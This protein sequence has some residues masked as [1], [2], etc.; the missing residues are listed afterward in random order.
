MRGSSCAVK[1]RNM[2][3]VRPFILAIFILLGTTYSIINPVLES[4]D[5]E[6]NY[7]NALYIVQN[8]ALPVL[9]PDEKSKAHHPP[10]YYLLTAALIDNIDHNKNNLAELSAHGNRFFG[11]NTYVPGVDNKIQNLPDPALTAFPWRGATLGIHI[12][13]LVSVIMGAGA[14]W[15]VAQIAWLL[16]K[17]DAISIAALLLTAFN[18]MFL[19][20]QSSVHN[21][22]LTNLLAAFTILATVRYWQTPTLKY[23]F[24]I[25]IVASLGILT[26]ITFLFLGI[27]IATVMICAVWKRN[28]RFSQILIAGTTV[29]TLTSWWFI[30]NFTICGD[31][32]CMNLQTEIWQ[33]RES[34]PD[35]SAAFGE[36]DYLF[37]SFWGAFGFG[38]ITYPAPIY[39]LF[40]ILT[41]IALIGLIRTKWQ[42]YDKWL[43]PLLIIAP[44]SAFAAT[45]WR[46]T[47]S[48]TANFGRYLFT[49]YAVIA[50]LLAIGL[51]AHTKPQSRKVLLYGLGGGMVLLNLYTLFGVIRP[52]YTPPPIINDINDTNDINELTI[53]HRTDIEYEHIGRLLGYDMPD[54]ADLNDTV[55]VTLYWQATD[56]IETN[57]AEFVQ[58]VTTDN[59]RIGG[60]DTF[61]GLGRY[62]TRYWQPND[63]IIDTIPIPLTTQTDTPTAV[64]LI[65]G[66]FTDD[67]DDRLPA[68]NGATTH[69]LG[70]IRLGG[71]QPAIVGNATDYRFDNVIQ[72][73]GMT[74]VVETAEAVTF[75]FTWKALEDVGRNV[76]VL[77]HLLDENGKLIAQSDSAPNNNSFPSCL[78]QHGDII[79][80]RRT[81]P[82]PADLPSG[83]YTLHI[84]LYWSDTIGRLSITPN[85]PNDTVPIYALTVE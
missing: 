18:P 74:D 1:Y 56:T 23:A 70:M 72:L 39:W 43:I 34:A 19:Y 85:S 41:L 79:I 52:V 32:T 35:W 12:M 24:T 67:S 54:S 50:P 78:W 77:V 22:A 10:L 42:K 30:R 13:R 63:I 27:M 38:Q 49:T 76:T 48:A 36:L 62:P 75:T 84:G 66:M 83:T 9:Q 60:R 61:H 33:P 17:N 14:A 2:H 81:Q 28:G 8:H 59:E 82:I 65:M 40:I 69:A 68:T 11:H 46:M 51:M 44:I 55:N 64:R 45:F 73:V 58:L 3:K 7:A 25:A 80:D 16:T 71:E 15:A 21:D 57:I 47:V 53:T 29:V 4:P 5:E 6:L 20:I 31:P 37:T 26:K